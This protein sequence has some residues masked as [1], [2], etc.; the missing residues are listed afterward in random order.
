[1]ALDCG[2]GI[3]RVSKNLLLKNFK[4]VEMVDVTE[5]FI[6]KATE[7]L[8]AEDAKRVLKFHCC[9]LQDFYPEPNKYDCVWIQWVSGYLNDNDFVDFLKRCKT[10]LKSN[11]I[12][13]LKENICQN[14]PELDADDSS[15]TRPRQAYLNLIHK[16][17]MVVIRDEKQRK[18][19]SFMP[20][21]GLKL[22]LI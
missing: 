12:C 11:G 5:N 21:L 6:A 14:E 9:G 2:A 13:I 4:N 1:M 7:Y 16:A 20:I 18:V 17:G 19:S 22:M 8:G 15:Y 3:G 10:S